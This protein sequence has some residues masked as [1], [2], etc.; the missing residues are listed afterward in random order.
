MLLVQYNLIYNLLQFESMHLD[1]W[2]INN[3]LEQLW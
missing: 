2:K 1:P 3:L